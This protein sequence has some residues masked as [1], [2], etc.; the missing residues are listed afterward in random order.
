MWEGCLYRQG[1]QIEG[2]EGPTTTRMFGPSAHI[3]QCDH[4]PIRA[5]LCTSEQDSG[6]QVRG[7]RMMPVGSGYGYGDGYG[8]VR[9]R[10]VC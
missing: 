3:Y 5:Q 2:K 10:K 8:T 4:A 1:R 9:M 7:A 6:A